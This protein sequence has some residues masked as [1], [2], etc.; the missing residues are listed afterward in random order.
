MT[1]VW[2]LFTMG[3]LYICA[4]EFGHFFVALVLGC[5]PKLTVKDWHIVMTYTNDARWKSRAIS[6]AGFVFGGVMYMI[7]MAL[8]GT[9]GAWVT[10][11]DIACYF[12]VAFVHFV[13]YPWTALPTANDFNGLCSHKEGSKIDE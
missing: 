13:L 4:H 9:P 10:S 1:Y 12:V 3:V 11:V 6:Q 5:Q 8:Y 2:S 7:L